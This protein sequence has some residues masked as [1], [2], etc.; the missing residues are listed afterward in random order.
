MKKEYAQPSIMIIEFP[1]E[2]SIVLDTSCILGDE[3]IP[4]DTIIEF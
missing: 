2:T 1:D 4:G 3:E